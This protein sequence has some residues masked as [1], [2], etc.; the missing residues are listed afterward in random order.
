MNNIKS[1]I[2]IPVA[3]I[4]C[5]VTFAFTVF[6]DTSAVQSFT[7]FRTAVSVYA[8][9]AFFDSAHKPSCYNTQITALYPSQ[10]VA[11]IF[12]VVSALQTWDTSLLNCHEVAHHVGK[13]V[14]RSSPEEWEVVM[15]DSLLYAQCANGYVHGI[16]SGLYEATPITMEDVH[17]ALPKFARL[18]AEGGSM[19]RRACLHGVGH[20]L[21]AATHGHMSSAFD[22]CVQLAGPTPSEDAVQACYG[23]VAMSMFMPLIPENT[24]LH[25]VET[26]TKDSLR[27][28]CS[29]LSSTSEI[30]VCLRSG[31]SLFGDDLYE[32]GFVDTFCSTQPNGTE[33]DLCYRKI[34]HGIGWENLA[35]PEK[36]TA[37]CHSV[38]KEKRQ[39]CFMIAAEEAI[40]QRGGHRGV[41]SAIALCR[42][43]DENMGN[44]CVTAVAE[45][46]GYYVPKGSLERRLYCAEVP[47]DL[48]DD[49]VNSIDQ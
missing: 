42:T 14:V 45:R 36:V 19:Q 24:D 6:S 2:I 37:F 35:T 10:S 39:E 25:N 4:V 3:A 27:E 31:W 26:V 28:F 40:T 23:G 16:A 15:R 13:K 49:C 44:R 12:D 48:L 22:L 17:S 18:C 33:S 41:A 30:G 7:T 29:T 47:R 46:A 11:K 32:P 1:Y 38:R 8:R 20:M 5:V 34:F 43:A 9:C 21:F